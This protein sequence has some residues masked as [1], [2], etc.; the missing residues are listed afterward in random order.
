MQLCLYV[1]HLVVHLIEFEVIL[2]I[3]YG[4]Q[5]IEGVGCIHQF[6]EVVR[7]VCTPLINT[8]AQPDSLF[9]GLFRP[10]GCLTLVH[11]AFQAMDLS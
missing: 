9:Y 8:R 2:A 7:P 3:L 5:L 4:K 11:C 6:V 1:L 10:T